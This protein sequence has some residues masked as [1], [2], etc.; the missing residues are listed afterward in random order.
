VIVCGSL[1]VAWVCLGGGLMMVQQFQNE[2]LKLWLECQSFI[3]LLR[4]YTPLL[5]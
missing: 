3:Y 5:V 2:K 1:V 4:L